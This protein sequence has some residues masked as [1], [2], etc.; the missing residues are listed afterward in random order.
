MTARLTLL[1]HGS[2]I[3]T[4][5]AAFPADDP[6]DAQGR[7]QAGALRGV[8][9]PDQ[10]LASPALSTRETAREM[11][12]DCAIDPLLRNC[13]Y[14][15]WSG[16]RFEDV[17][18]RQPELISEWLSNPGAAPHGGETIL[19]LI[20]RASAWLAAR[21]KTP[22]KALAISHPAVIRA[23]VVRAIDANPRSFWRIDLPPLSVVELFG[24][25]DRWTLR[26]IR[27]SAGVRRDLTLFAERRDQ[28]EEAARDEATPFAGWRGG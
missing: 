3:A 17:R 24:D 28:M 21:A 2:T 23:I 11:R 25:G 8:F 26:S 18:S 27:K 10:C 12:L 20:E 14:G 5:Q 15:A 16:R 7:R 4:R 19:D 13:D 22:A 6:L 1:C 9:R